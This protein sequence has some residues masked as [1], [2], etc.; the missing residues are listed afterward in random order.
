MGL[1]S[2]CIPCFVRDLPCVVTYL[3]SCA[4]VGQGSKQPNSGPTAEHT[5]TKAGTKVWR[6]AG[7]VA[8]S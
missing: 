1:A 4:Y 3:V 7:G 2:C 5:W 6:G 8:A